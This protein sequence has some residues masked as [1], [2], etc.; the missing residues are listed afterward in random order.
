[1]SGGGAGSP[2]LE[3]PT[4]AARTCRRSCARGGIAGPAPRRLSRSCREKRAGVRAAAPGLQEAEAGGSRGRSED[5]GSHGS[6]LREHVAVDV[7]HQVPAGRVL[8]DEAHVFGRLEAAEQVHKEG[9][10]RA[11]HSRQDSLLA[12]QARA[13]AGDRGPAEFYTP[14]P[15]ALG[16]LDL[17]AAGLQQD[18]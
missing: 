17:R 11:G 13:G 14:K 15:Q 3:P 2:R 7:Q 1:M 16:G 5:R 10:P 4:G 6:G 12:H 18:F 8:H 9:V